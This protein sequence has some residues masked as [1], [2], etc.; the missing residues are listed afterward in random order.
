[1][2]Y[3]FSYYISHFL[4]LFILYCFILSQGI[5]VMKKKNRK[6]SLLE[7]GA[8]MLVKFAVKFD[9]S[10]LLQFGSIFPMHFLHLIVYTSLEE[11]HF[12]ISISGYH[13]NIV[14]KV[15]TSQEI[16]NQVNFLDCLSWCSPSSFYLHFFFPS[17][18]IQEKVQGNWESV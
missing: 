13:W 17:F 1:M 3:S 4:N 10:T 6:F 12:F 16:Q 15:N 5:L 7:N 11:L 9:S 18:I 8:I 14:T 2:N